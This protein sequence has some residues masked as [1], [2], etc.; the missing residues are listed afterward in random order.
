MNNLRRARFARHLRQRGAIGFQLL[1]V[2]HRIKSNVRLVIADLPLASGLEEQVDHP[3]G[4]CRTVTKGE[5]CLLVMLR[6][7]RLTPELGAR[8]RL[9]RVQGVVQN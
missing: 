5:R 7:L 9:H 2:C 1:L 6:R 4:E 8:H 3:I